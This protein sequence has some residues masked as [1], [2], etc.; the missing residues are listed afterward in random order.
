MISFVVIFGTYQTACYFSFEPIL[1]I[2]LVITTV[3]LCAYIVMNRGFSNKP[4]ESDVLP[5]DWDEEKKRKY[6]EEDT[7]RKK[8]SKKLMIFI[9]PFVLTFFIDMIY[10]FYI[11]E[12]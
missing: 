5:S 3:L 6:I 2:Y 7:E 12:A 8:K 11:F 10:L 4:I 9:L 1:P